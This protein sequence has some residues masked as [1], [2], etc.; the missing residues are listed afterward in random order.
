MVLSLKTSV[1]ERELQ[2]HQNDAS[3]EVAQ[4]KQT[5]QERNAA[6]LKLQENLSRGE[7]AIRSLE[8]VRVLF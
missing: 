1:K 8:L 4:L 3:T 2:L 5:L 6:L 7:A